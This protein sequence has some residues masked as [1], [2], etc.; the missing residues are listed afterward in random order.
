METP[1]SLARRFRVARPWLILG[2]AVILLALAVVS[3]NL[4]R[5]TPASGGYCPES[6]S[7]ILTAPDPAAMLRALGRLDLAGDSGGG[8]P[9]GDLQ[10]AVR[11]AAG[12]RPTASRWRLWAGR[13]IVLALADE[14]AGA[15]VR[16]GMLV[17]AA[18]A[19]LR[20]TG[21]VRV[22]EGIREREGMYY[23]WRDGF[24]VIS[25]SRAYVL[26]SLSAPPLPVKDAA[27]SQALYLRWTGPHK[28]ELTLKA[29]EG[30]PVSGRMQVA[31]SERS[32]PL[33]LPHAWPEPPLIHITATSWSDLQ[34]ITDAAL[35][36]WEGWR[37]LGEGVTGWIARAR[38][39]P[40]IHQWQQTFGECS[41]ALTGI[42]TSRPV[43]V[44]EAVLVMRSPRMLSGRHP[45]R[46]MTV[47]LPIVPYS[48][49]GQP[50]SISPLLGE[51]F[52]LCLGRHGRDWLAASRASALG[53]V[54]GRL[55]EGSPVSAD[56]LLQAHW[57]RLATTL[58]T[59]LREAAK[60][61]MLPGWNHD[62]VTRQAV[63]LLQR[64]A[65]QGGLHI[66]GQAGGPWLVFSGQLAY[67]REAPDEA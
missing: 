26:A 48:W 6:A 22:Q 30:L 41:L 24:L 53:G 36:S 16:P 12:V 38:I 64:L 1:L 63:P 40:P 60:G 10:L 20:L 67:P 51:K 50:G 7:C 59:L 5:G 55:G 33:T 2:V 4:F 47:G 25:P 39:Q 37:R 46:G 61:E 65:R 56:V 43:P 9:A 28:G 62:D 66:E 3:D 31:L 29:A 18:D 14:G 32:E 35:G 19:W 17:R 49:E 13:G 34:A 57:P 15:C 21:A 23:A 8:S 11:K 45:L 27:D 52:S 42:D 58:E 54:A 44:P